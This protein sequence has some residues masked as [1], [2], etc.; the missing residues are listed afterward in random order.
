MPPRSTGLAAC[1]A[2]RIRDCADGLLDSVRQVLRVAAAT[3]CRT[4]ISHLV[5]VG[6]RNHGSVARALELINAA[7]DAG[8]DVAFDIYPYLAGNA[9]LSQLLPARAQEGGEGPLRARLTEPAVRARVRDEW[10]GMPNSWSDIAVGGRTLPD[11]AADAGIDPPEVALDLVAEHGNG[12]Q[13]VAGG[14]SERDLADALTHPAGVIGSDGQARDP[15]VPT[16]RDTPH[17]RSF[18]CYP[19]LFAEYVRTGRIGIAE[20]VRKCTSAAERAGLAGRGVL[21]DGAAADIVVFDPARIADRATFTAPQRYPEG[22]SAVIVAG[23]TVV[24]NN[25]H[26]G[27]RPG[28]ILRIR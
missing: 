25:T 17:P 18:G 9:P 14:R 7:R 6:E 15:D 3:G 26:N 20:A 12:V 23:Q 13:M 2:T 27:A 8:L 21:R 5:A 16:G 4:Q 28:E 11:L 22:I 10:S 24:E 19:R 1:S